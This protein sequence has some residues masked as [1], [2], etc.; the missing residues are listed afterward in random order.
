MTTST[1]PNASAHSA[2]LLADG[3]S[4]HI[5]APAA[6]TWDDAADWELTIIEANPLA[7]L[8]NGDPL[9]IERPA[10]WAEF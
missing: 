8:F 4:R 10:T 6:P 7:P 1:L 3:P 2:H 9:F 5:A